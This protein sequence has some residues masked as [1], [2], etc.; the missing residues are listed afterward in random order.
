MSDESQYIEKA[1]QG[2]HAAFRR[3]YDAHITPLYRFMRQFEGNSDQVEEWVQRAFIKAY[4]NIGQFEKSAKFSTW[5]F[6]LALNEMKMDRRTM[7]IIPLETVYDEDYSSV[8]TNEEFEWNDLM[9]AW[10]AELSETKR[11]V[12]LLYEVEGY[13][14]AEIARMLGLG[15]STSRTILARTKQFLQTQWQKSREI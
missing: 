14:H 4:I 10:L 6:R 3:L 15:E 1:K 8:N 9:K 11:M 7:A 12:F 13:S 2:N 5:L